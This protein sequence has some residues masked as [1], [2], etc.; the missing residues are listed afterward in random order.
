MAASGHQ[1][2]HPESADQA[3]AASVPIADAP[4]AAANGGRSC[5]E[6]HGAGCYRHAPARV[7]PGPDCA[8]R[9]QGARVNDRVGL[10]APPP[11][12]FVE[13]TR[14]KMT[15][16][17]GNPV[18]GVKLVVVTVCENSKLAKLFVVDASIV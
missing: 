9:L 14:Q 1:R 6:L 4:G 3:P 7:F 5:A 2:E 10:K 16:L 18:V 8:R 15:V 11:Q 13:R 12:L 17:P